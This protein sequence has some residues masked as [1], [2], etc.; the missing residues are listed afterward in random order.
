MSKTELIILAIGLSVLIWSGIIWAFP[1]TLHL[2]GT[3]DYGMAILFLIVSAVILLAFPTVL[4][5]A[6]VKCSKP[7]TRNLIW[8]VMI[9]LYAILP[10][11][12]GVDELKYLY[13]W[14]M[15]AEAQKKLCDDN[16]SYKGLVA[17]LSRTG[18]PEDYLLTNMLGFNRIVFAERYILE[19]PKARFSNLS[20]MMYRYYKM[21]K[22]EHNKSNY[23]D[24]LSRQAS[25]VAAFLLDKGWDINAIGTIESGGD[26]NKRRTALYIA[27]LYRDLRTA[28]LLLERGAD[29]NS[30]DYSCLWIA[31]IRN[32]AKRVRMLIERGVN[33]KKDYGK[34]LLY[35]AVESNNTEIVKMLLDAGAKCKRDE[36]LLPLVDKQ[37]NP[38]LWSLLTQEYEMYNFID[39]DK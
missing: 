34:S 35:A 11:K 37:T 25:A 10:A 33:L 28:N 7:A 32:D 16:I 39:T 9:T 3:P 19:N 26:N 8:G 17:A 5:G 4:I 22:M 30:G 31:I 2:G 36:F 38:E 12:V 29:V 14:Q 6:V 15:V 21:N 20:D 1:K 23:S 27:I 13:H 24:S 18:Y